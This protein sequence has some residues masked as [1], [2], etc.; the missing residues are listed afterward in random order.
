MVPRMRGAVDMTTVLED[1]DLNTAR[2]DGC[3]D[4]TTNAVQYVD[5]GGAIRATYCPGCELARR[6]YGIEIANHDQYRLPELVD[7]RDRRSK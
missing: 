2:C 1:V 4:E 7:E 3:G 5:D 6:N